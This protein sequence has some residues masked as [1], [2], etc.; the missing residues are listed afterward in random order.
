M[1]PTLLWTLLDALGLAFSLM[2]A[3]DR[4]YLHPTHF[5]IGLKMSKANFILKLK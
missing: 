3:M 1:G 5:L 4:E 2:A